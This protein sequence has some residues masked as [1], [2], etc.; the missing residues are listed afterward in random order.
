MFDIEQLNNEINTLKIETLSKY[1]KKV[2]ITIELIKK[3]EHL[4]NRYKKIKDRIPGK[5]NTC[6]RK[7][8]KILQSVAKQIEDKIKLAENRLLKLISLREKYIEE[9]KFQRESLGISEHT[10]IDE[11]YKNR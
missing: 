4:L 1:G 10:F 11:F 2:D 5:I 7:K 3:E 8:R 6:G 9:Y